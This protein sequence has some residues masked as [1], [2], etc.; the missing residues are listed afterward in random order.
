MRRTKAQL[1]A[2]NTILIIFIVVI[3]FLLIS[4]FIG[5]VVEKDKNFEATKQSCID[6]LID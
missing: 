3:S 2:E 4:C 1:E 5:L 6:L